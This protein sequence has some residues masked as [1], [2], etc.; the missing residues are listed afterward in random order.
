MDLLKREQIKYVFRPPKYSAALIPLLVRFS[1]HLYLRRKYNVQQ[2]KVRG[3]EEV[4]KLCAQGHSVLVAPNHADHADPHAMAHV[5]R[6]YDLPFHFMAAREVFEKQGAIGNWA[7][8][9][10]G[11]FSVDREGA[12]FSAIKTAMAL[13]RQGRH[14]LV[15]FPEGEIYHHHER[16]APLNE[17]VATILLRSMK[18]RE[19][20]D[21]ESYLVPTALRYAYDES[22]AGTYSARLSRLEERIT[23]KPREGSDPVD[24]IYRLGSGLLATKEVEFLGTSSSGELVERIVGL[25]HALVGRIENAH[26]GEER[27]GTIPERVKALRSTIRVELTDETLEGKEPQ[28]ERQLYDDLDTI[29]VAVQLYS[30][31]GQ[32]LKESPTLHRIAE[33][34]VKLEEDVLGEGSYPT[35]RSVTV[36]FGE[37][38]SVRGFLD[39][40]GLTV[41]KAVAPLTEILADDIQSML[42]EL[43]SEDRLSE[44]SP[45]VSGG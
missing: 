37:P 2:V 8:Q 45:S 34:L 21:N 1:D 22:V 10:M 4:A 15:I 25:Q 38:I 42:E 5:G 20:E 16:L 3:A 11:A 33:T 7:L 24:R 41:K 26:Y 12:D 27:D 19:A 32:Y 43:T 13:L 6:R 40:L 39:R 18:G 9:R 29:F 36:R 31:P 44:D 17:G 14:P 23:W 30:Y 28:R 35:P